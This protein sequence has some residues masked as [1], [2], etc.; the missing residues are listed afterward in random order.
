M[1]T[2]LISVLAFSALALPAEAQGIR[3]DCSLPKPSSAAKVLLLSAYEGDA[4][5]TTAIGSQDIAVRTASIDV[6]A[7]DEPLYVVALSYRPM[8]WR[9]TGAVGR[10]ELVVLAAQ[11]TE[12]NGSRPDARP[13]V[14]ANGV[15]AGKVVFL[16]KPTCLG[17]FSEVPSAEA[18]RTIATV[19]KETGKDPIIAAD[20]A[21]SGISVPSAKLKPP[22]GGTDVRPTIAIENDGKGFRVDLSGKPRM[23]E[24]GNAL[25]NDVMRFYPGGVVEIDPTTVV[26]SGKP[27]RYEVL[28][29]KAGLLQL[30]RSGVLSESGK[31]EFVIKEK[32]RFPAGLY[33]AE[34]ARFILSRG[35]PAPEG[36]PG[37]SCLVKE[38]DN[39]TAVDPDAEC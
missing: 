18:A 29:G 21:I 16:P 37:H 13:I 5:S 23:E 6:E 11:A 3:T 28:P 2:G 24:A 26:A 22:N 34:S 12:A 30:I 7:G 35:V 17:D 33:G 32:M 31:G 36:D 25:E 4:L 20:Y 14:G 10:V 15:A 19:R 38:E 9:L 1:K 39:K 27:A 8:I